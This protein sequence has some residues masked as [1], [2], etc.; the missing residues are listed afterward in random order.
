MKVIFIVFLFKLKTVQYIV[1]NL[2]FALMYKD[3]WYQLLIYLETIFKSLYHLL[4]EIKSHVAY[5]WSF[6]FCLRNVFDD[7]SPELF[8]NK[9][10]K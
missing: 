7:C 10:V 5:F 3:G 9:S 2:N 4:E 6:I 8:E 1:I